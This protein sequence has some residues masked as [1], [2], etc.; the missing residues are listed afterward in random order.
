MDWKDRIKNKGVR[1]LPGTEDLLWQLAG[2]PTQAPSSSIEDDQIERYRW[3][4][5]PT[6]ESRRFEERLAS[7]DRAME[8]LAKVAAKS[9]RGRQ[10]AFRLAASILVGALATA[11]LFYSLRTDEVETVAFTVPPYKIEVHGLADR[12]GA[13]PEASYDT[14]PGSTVRIVARPAT[15]AG[16]ELGFALYRRDEG[17]LARIPDESLRIQVER[18]TAVLEAEAGSLVGAVPGLYEL[19]LLIGARDFSAPATLASARLDALVSEQA[20]QAHTFELRLLPGDGDGAKAA[21]T[22]TQSGTESS[23]LSWEFYKEPCP[24]AVSLYSASCGAYGEIHFE[25][26]SSSCEPFDSGSGQPFGYPGL[27]I[28]EKPKGWKNLSAQNDPRPIV[29]HVRNLPAKAPTTGP[30]N[31]VIDWQNF[32]G[33]TVSAI[34]DVLSGPA[35]PTVSLYLDDPS[36]APL[37][38]EIRDQH[39]LVNLCAAANAVDNGIADL[40]TVTLSLGRMPQPSDP[41]SG[42]TC[43][44]TLSCHIGKVAEHLVDREVVIVAAAGNHGD[45]LFPASLDE[46]IA[47]GSL[48]IGRYLTTGELDVTW[49]TPLEVDAAVPGYG[50]CLSGATAPSGSSFASAFLAGGVARLLHELPGIDPYADRW[51]TQ[52]SVQLQCLVLSQDGVEL[53]YCNPEFDNILAGILIGAPSGCWDSPDDTSVAVVPP[54]GASEV[55]PAAPGLVQWVDENLKPAPQEDPC[56]PCT[57]DDSYPPLLGDLF[58]NTTQSMPLSSEITLHS[59]F[60]RTGDSFYPVELSPEDLESFARAELDGLRLPGFMD[61]IEPGTFPSLYY[62]LKMDPA[63]DCDDPAQVDQCFWSSSYVYP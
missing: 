40:S 29:A 12:R 6:A 13:E 4:K 36:L 10:P 7:D 18:G 16:T 39:L 57:D 53:P 1:L 17:A 49:E 21:H 60:F 43:G 31:L 26:T 55:R 25:V 51:L 54:A 52:W 62:L 2:L 47:A 11:G 59:V 19:V 30:W 50:L 5:L 37:G 22:G 42:G 28:K 20:L 9:P 46:T 56:I 32:H 34:V 8:R 15:A 44:G 48:D 3:G 63:L 23:E 58:L 14:M 24:D 27:E 35:V 45:L 41:V 38:T 33:L 61:L